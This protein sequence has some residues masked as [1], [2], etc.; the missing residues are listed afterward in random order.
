[1]THVSEPVTHS[2]G[3]S[4]MA[5]R[6]MSLILYSNTG[7]VNISDVVSVGENLWEFPTIVC[8]IVM[9]RC[10]LGSALLLRSLI[11]AY[12]SGVPSSQGL[13]SVS[14]SLSPIFWLQLVA[15]L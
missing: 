3:D 1:M 9:I 13:S 14:G 15:D 5:W 12:D 8:D 6:T 7:R 2:T 10:L 11:P 4:I